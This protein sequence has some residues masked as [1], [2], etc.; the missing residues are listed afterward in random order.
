[1][2]TASLR[3]F[4]R[5]LFHTS[6]KARPSTRRL[7]VEALEDRLLLS[8]RVW[9]GGPDGGTTPSADANWTTGTNWAGDVAPQP[10]DDLQF[11][12]SA[13]Q[14]AANNDFPAGTA[15]N[16]IAISGSGYNLGGNSIALAAGI[17][18]SNP[19]GT[20]TS[21]VNTVGMPLTLTAAGA[22]TSGTARTTLVLS[23][24][25]L[26]NGG[27][28]LT[29]KGAGDVFFSG[30]AITGAGGLV[31]NGTGQLF[32]GDSAP[33]TY[34]GATTV[35]QG[36]LNL[37]SQAGNSV[38]G[39]LVVGS[40]ISGAVGAVAR[41][42]AANQIPNT[43]PVTVNGTGQLDL[44]G[45][46]DT[47]GP[48][49][50]SAGL[51]TTG[52]GVLTLNGDVATVAASS[53]ATISGHLNLGSGTTAR[54]F[55]LAYGTA[56]AD[57]D[58]KATIAG[59]AS[60][61]LTKQGPGFLLLEGYNT[62]AGP[63]LVNAGT[64]WID[65]P[66]ALGATTAGTTVNSGASLYAMDPT[67]NSTI[68]FAPEPLILNGN[69]DPDLVGGG[70]F[71]GDGAGSKGDTLVWPGQI[72]LASPS[73]IVENAATTLDLTG[74]V[75]GPGDLTKT[76]C[77][78]VK[79]SHDNGYT[80]A[81]VVNEGILEANH[82]ASLGATGPASGTTVTGTGTL[83]LA[84]GVT[85][86]P[87]SLTLHGTGSGGSSGGVSALHSYG[88]NTWTGPVY[89]AT[90]S[91]VNVTHGGTLTISGVIDGPSAS[92]LVVGRSI[93]NWDNGTVLLTAAN[94][95][96][97]ATTVS[98]GTLAA[99]N[100]TALGS[101]ACGP[102]GGTTVKA[103]ATLQLRGGLTFDPTEALTLND[104]GLNDV[105]ALQ[106]GSGNNT[107]AGTIRLATSASI[108]AASGTTLTIAGVIGGPA[109]STL[110]KAGWGAVV[111][112]TGNTYAGPTVVAAGTLVAADP[113]ALGA[114][115]AG[116]TVKDCATLQLQGGIAFNPEPL[117]LNGA[118]TG[119]TAGALRNR[120]GANTWTG[121]I[122]LG[123]AATVRA[124]AGSSLTVSGAVANEGY[125][126]TVN[127]IGAVTF[128]Y[129]ISGAGGLTK[130]GGGTLTFAATAPNTYAGPTT[131]NAGTLVLAGAA[132]IPAIGGGSV[133]I[134][135]G[136]TLAGSGII[137]ANVTNS[138][139]I[140]VGGAGTTGTLTINGNYTQ[141]TAGVLNVALAGTDPSLYDHLAVSG[142]AA[143]DGTLNVGLLNGFVPV[144]GNAFQIVTF[145][146]WSGS[147]AT[148]NGLNPG[149]GV[150]L[151]VVYDPS[152]VTL[153]AQT[154]PM[155]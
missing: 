94:T 102:N 144:A 10:G 17:T 93:A 15:F 90:T 128:G 143:L 120:S 113:A 115:T 29:V 27:F 23:S 31:K 127:S 148:V 36:I 132:N 92:G 138:G 97:G 145:A 52:S 11:P 74:L 153:L 71:Q 50:L 20:P 87:E 37:W 118:G 8:T 91:Q 108:G 112:A 99:A 5:R 35:K 83:Q 64:L 62:Y 80:G 47:I 49:T 14:F 154:A 61:T 33:N 65:S 1:M 147:F 55:N 81:T 42:S 126:L 117:T 57:L 135:A 134:N 69:G 63:T 104:S 82:P 21:P 72:T 139:T 114:I 12:A 18:T 105:G 136:G 22:I 125:L 142:T 59:D 77:G 137:D 84:G 141:T 78:A 19:T 26:N 56:D 58:I 79:L 76:G 95:Y 85:F 122:S 39:P 46:T 150:T 119:E 124:D 3:S 70:A 6:T 88:S 151:A 4:V 129:T 111:L 2:A 9:D 34:G 86:A 107:W 131:I 67:E 44:N 140:N 73:V 45:F 54:T 68:T 7:A 51:V 25:I 110:T 75:T 98:V 40:G 109:A 24:P 121:A 103:E 28:D 146:S 106:N 53:R 30:G 130:N 149:N 38:P 16:S 32:L 48:L 152:D 43:A 41:L 89:L 96:A 13:L 66:H 155:P 100:A 60:V 123:S 101:P 133:Q 116:T